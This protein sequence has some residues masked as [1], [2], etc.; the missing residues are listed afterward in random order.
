MP[1]SRMH[2]I[3]PVERQ[4]YIPYCKEC[5]KEI[6]VVYIRQSDGKR[7]TFWKHGYPGKY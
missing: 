2:V 1:I 6:T 5:G 3:T 7:V 4:G